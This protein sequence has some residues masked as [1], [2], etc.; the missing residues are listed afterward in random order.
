M[1]GFGCL[2]G[3]SLL[4]TLEG[5]LRTARLAHRVK[6]LFPNED[7]VNEQ[8]WDRFNQLVHYTRDPE[9]VSSILE[10]GFL[11]VPNRRNLI[12]KLLN[13]R[14]FANREPQ[15]FG[16]VSFTELRIAEAARH[17]ESFGEFGIAVSWDWALRHNAQRVI[18]LGE[19]SVTDTFAWLFQLARQELQRKS[20]EPVLEFTLANRAVAS[21][22]SQFY[23]HLLTLYEFMEPERSSSQVEWRIVN[24]L[25]DYMDLTDRALM[26]QKLIQQAKS[27]KL[28]TIRVA[29]E[30]VTMLIA[31][32]KQIAKLHSAIPP[33]FR[34]LPVL[35]LTTNP[36]ISKLVPVLGNLIESRL[37]RLPQEDP[38]IAGEGID[39][40]RIP[41]V[42]KIS[43]LT[44]TPDDVL[45]RAHVQVQYHSDDRE[46]I[47]M[48]MPFIEATRLHGYLHAVMTDPKLASLVELATR[49]L[50][51]P[52]KG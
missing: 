13:T 27:W 52:R 45:D 44:V 23:A 7:S 25:P 40:E 42:T 41:E 29:P 24:S 16:M 3:E 18:Y 46:F 5:G 22:Y 8:S 33:R 51:R 49:I 39:L 35:P 38:V 34:R 36:W 47:E 12:Q 9:T 19:G 32:P 31:P 30:D 20:P 6:A 26:I 21:T 17:R 28:G 14:E 50:R 37:Q 43:G 2:R 1:P 10:N 11:L 48:K 15:Q 4:P